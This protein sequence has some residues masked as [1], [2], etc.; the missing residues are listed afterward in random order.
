MDVSWV[1]Q[2]L[3]ALQVN[4][5]QQKVYQNKNSVQTMEINE[6]FDLLYSKTNI[7][8]VNLIPSTNSSVI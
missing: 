7:F 6:T 5:L 8:K 4:V 2:V 3:L 1:L